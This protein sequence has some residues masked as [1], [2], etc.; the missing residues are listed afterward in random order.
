MGSANTASSSLAAALDFDHHGEGALA[1]EGVVGDA[2]LG[3]P[4]V[5]STLPRPVELAAWE[6]LQGDGPEAIEFP[7]VPG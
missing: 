6:R 7:V 1:G 3:A 5:S 2:W 4:V